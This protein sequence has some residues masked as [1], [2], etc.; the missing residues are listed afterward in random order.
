MV[1]TCRQP[2]AAGIQAVAVLHA[3]AAAPSSLPTRVDA[4]PLS[5]CAAKKHRACT[6]KVMP[7]MDM[8][9][10]G[11]GSSPDRMTITSNVHQS[12]VRGRHKG[13]P[14]S[15]EGGRARSAGQ[16]LP[17]AVCLRWGSYGRALVAQGSRDEARALVGQGSRDEAR[18]LVSQRSRD[19]AR[20]LVAQ[21]SRD[22]ARGS[23]CLR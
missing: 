10:S 16:A 15:G 20:A 9:I 4:A 18:A 2:R 12:C 11:R 19:E 5:P 21:G 6:L 23:A 17:Y 3:P 1:C 7:I 14:G 22:E 8:V 13:G